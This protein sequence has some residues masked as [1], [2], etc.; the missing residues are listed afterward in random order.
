PSS[1][2]E[3]IPRVCQCGRVF[4]LSEST[5][6]A[7]L[8]PSDRP[9]RLKFGPEPLSEF[10]MDRLDIPSFLRKRAETDEAE[11]SLT[12]PVSRA[13]QKRPRFVG[14]LLRRAISFFSSRRSPRRKNEA[15]KDVLWEMEA[16]AIPEKVV[17]DADAA[18]RPKPMSG[19]F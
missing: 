17:E 3:G 15:V 1:P 2:P 9:G 14:R 7:N 8:S 13:S 6:I 4:P 19:S 11:T 10:G 18:E 16:L 5:V 12:Q